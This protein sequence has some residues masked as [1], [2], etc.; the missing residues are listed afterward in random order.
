VDAGGSAL[1]SYLLAGRDEVL[2]LGVAT[3][4]EEAQ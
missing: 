4:R 1:S 3:E 2:K